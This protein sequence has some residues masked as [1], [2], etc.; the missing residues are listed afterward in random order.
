ME[1]NC[2]IEKLKG[3]QLGPCPDPEAVDLEPVA[4]PTR[5]LAAARDQEA[6]LGATG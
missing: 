1:P 6:D 5:A 2:R 3:G 4:A